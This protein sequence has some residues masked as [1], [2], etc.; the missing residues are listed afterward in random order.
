LPVNG[1]INKV[2][3]IKFFLLLVIS[4]L[5][6][7]QDQ[8]KIGLGSCNNQNYPTPAW[9]SLEKENLDSFF[10][11]GDNVYGDIP[12]GELDYLVESYQ[13]F[14]LNMPK[15]LK[16]TE[17]FVIWDD[18]DY[19]LNDGGSS[20]KYKAESQILFNNFWKVPT[21]DDR[22]SREGIYFSAKKT[23]AGKNVL[24]IGLDTRYFRSDLIKEN[25]RY[26][27]NTDINATILGKDQWNWLINE[28]SQPH[29]I[30]ILATSIQLLATE[31]RFEKWS[32]FPRERDKL[33]SLLDKLD[34]TVLVVSGDR[35]RG[36]IY[37][38]DNIIEITA[39]SLNRGIFPSFETDT[40]LLGNTHTI[41][42]YGVF[43]LSNTNMNIYLKDED[44][45]ILESLE[46]PIK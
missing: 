46:I 25:D 13:V 35:H 37:Q 26:V 11:L 10:F 3:I 40:L 9:S 28:I 41:H 6:F 7:A 14:N 1:K 42:N 30:L 31:H 22:R 24:I 36:G 12:S 45:N 32:N 33:L 34:S 21:D 19:G 23:I 2:K 15:W 16:D 17:L 39:S 27:Q 5:F 38:K 43:E 4:N 20:Y 44:M 29:D 18:H 8:Y